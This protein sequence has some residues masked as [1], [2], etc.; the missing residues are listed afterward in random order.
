MDTVVAESPHSLATSRIVIVVPVFVLDRVTA[1]S[2]KPG[3]FD[4]ATMNKTD[5]VDESFYPS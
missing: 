5:S 2:S 1:S 4:A 3:R